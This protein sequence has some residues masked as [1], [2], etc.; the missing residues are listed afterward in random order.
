[1]TAV[2]LALCL[3]IVSGL[4]TFTS[5]AA[6]L[7]VRGGIWGIVAAVAACGEYVLDVTPNAPSRTHAV[8]ISAR[9]VSG[10][11]VGWVIATTHG[12]AGVL[13]VVAG[14]A[15]A[16]IGTYGGH[17]ARVAA[18]VRI[19]DYPAALAEDLVAIGLAAF[20]VTR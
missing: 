1:V 5:P 4:R 14:V 9:V 3:G 20:I 13:G 10:A 11:L 16:L 6:L 15:G 18:I 7:L 12:G 8:G 2:L 19:G 17:A